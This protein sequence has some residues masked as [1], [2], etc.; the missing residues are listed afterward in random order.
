M[1]V[2]R[3]RRGLAAAVAAASLVLLGGCY[4]YLT[5]PPDESLAGR[6]AQLW[7]S[8]SGAVVLASMIGPAAESLVGRVLSDTGATVIVALERVH[9]RGGNETDWRGEQIAVSR[10]LIIDTGTRRFSASR[11]ALFS[12]IVGAGL[13][14][15]RQ[16]FQG[17]GTGG[18]G[19]GVGRSGGFR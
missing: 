10:T 1:S 13:I 17:R 19:G 4:G 9:Q 16:A 7:L 18:S 3:V 2:M 11:T 12:G 8:D 5:P 6:S 14:A 15:A